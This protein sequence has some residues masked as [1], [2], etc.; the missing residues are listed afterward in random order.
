MAKQEQT[1]IY[2]LAI[3]RESVRLALSDEN[4]KE[5]FNLSPAYPYITLWTIQL[6]NT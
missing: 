2:T 1:E 3:R 6:P 4:I 5:I